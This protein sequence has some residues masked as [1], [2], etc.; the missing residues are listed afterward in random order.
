[1]MQGAEKPLQKK[2]EYIS[3]LVLGI[4]LLLS[5]AWVSFN[6]TIGIL[7]GGLISILNFYGLVR[8]LQKFLGPS[9]N[10][11]KDKASVIYKYLLRLLFTGFALYFVIVKTTANIF[12]LV[13]GLSTVVISIV[14]SVALASIDKS[15]LEEV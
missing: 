2:I 5:G 13:I 6:F 14:F 7:F 11:G 12:G 1:M 9:G 8:G 3:W 4:L 10:T 15:Y